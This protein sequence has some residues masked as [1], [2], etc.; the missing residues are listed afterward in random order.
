M[1]LFDSIDLNG[2]S[3]NAELATLLETPVI[4]II[5]V[6]GATR[7]IVPIIQG[8]IRFEPKINIAGVI[9]NNIAGKRHEERLR[10]VINHY[11]DI[12]IV[13]AIHRNHSLII[14]ERH[15]GLIP[16]NESRKVDDKVAEIAQII[17][18]QV[19]LDLLQQIA[20]EAPPFYKTVQTAEKAPA[21]SPLRIGIAQDAAFGF[22][23]PD[24]LKKFRA[25]GAELVPFSPLEDPLLP[26]GLDGLFI[27]GGFPETHLEQLA[28]N[29]RIKTSIATAIEEGLP[30]YAE[31]GGLMYLSRGIEWRGDRASMVGIIPASCRVYKKPVGRGYARLETTAHHPWPFTDVAG[32]FPAHEFHYSEL[33]E[34]SSDFSYAY[35]M[36]RGAGINGEND[37]FI[38]KNL[39]ANYI[40]LR[41]VA[42]TPWV[43]RFLTFV[44]E[45]KNNR[46]QSAN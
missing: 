18:S 10:E 21:L 11:I 45:I 24:D 38:Y 19:D 14:D 40:H 4:L 31:C 36:V 6:E 37:G 39:L 29:Q 2:G 13:G 46:L 15:L 1:G 43:A 44:E 32:E 12:P 25:L 41:S 30:C 34:L 27:G 20:G 8:F 5:N 9:L 35:R 28:S 3:S 17:G 33:D 23:Y 26:E 7:S 22:Y 42:S 16:S